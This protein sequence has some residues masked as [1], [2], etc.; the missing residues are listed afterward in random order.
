MN[1]L[2]LVFVDNCVRFENICGFTFTTLSARVVSAF[3]I[4]TILICHFVA[5]EKIY[6]N[7]VRATQ[8]KNKQKK[9]ARLI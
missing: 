5:L 3:A 2:F 9:N 6:K 4:E 8:F 1:D 7:C